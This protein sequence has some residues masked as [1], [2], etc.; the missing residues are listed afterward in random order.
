MVELGLRWRRHASRARDEE[1]GAR[2]HPLDTISRDPVETLEEEKESEHD[3]EGG[4]EV[5]SGS[6]RKQEGRLGSRPD[7]ELKLERRRRRSS[8]MTK[9]EGGMVRTNLNMVRARIDSVRKYHDLSYRCCRGGARRQKGVSDGTRRSNE[10]KVRE[11]G[12]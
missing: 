6:S 4:I 8:V 10:Q 7:R 5:L 3:D 9:V 11:E 2:T 12:G 1:K